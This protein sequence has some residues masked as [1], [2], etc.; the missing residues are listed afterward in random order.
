MQYITDPDMEM[1]YE[2]NA[3]RKAEKAEAL[4]KC[5]ARV[6]HEKAKRAFWRTVRRAALECGSC[7]CLAGMMAV[8]TARDMV[9][10]EVSGPIAL[11]CLI[12]GVW[13]G[14]MYWQQLNK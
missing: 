4:R 14:A 6:A 5:Q 13:R 3:R 7:L 11:A 10:P 12:V 1:I 9:S 8:Y 2:I